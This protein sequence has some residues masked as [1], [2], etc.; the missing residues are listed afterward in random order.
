MQKSY[1]ALIQFMVDDFGS[2]FEDEQRLAT[3]QMTSDLYPYEA[4]FLP[5]QVN[6]LKLK[7]RIVMGPMGNVC[8]AD[9]TGRPSH[10]MVAYRLPGRPLLMQKRAPLTASIFT[11]MR[12]ICWSR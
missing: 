11:G 10:K 5:I 6:H 4:L 9:E 3:G 1:Q 12:D 8:M 2:W 7:N